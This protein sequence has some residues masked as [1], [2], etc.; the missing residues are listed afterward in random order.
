MAPVQV[1][2]VAVMVVHEA[3]H[4]RDGGRGVGSGA[5]GAVILPP[6]TP[7]SL[8]LH[9]LPLQSPLHLN[10]TQQKNGESVPFWRDFFVCKLVHLLHFDHRMIP[11]DVKFAQKPS[12]GRSRQRKR[13]NTVL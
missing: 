1:L 12:C 10:V 6:L 11:P 13:Q 5:H 7:L 2:S 3:R 8:I 4:L 9:P